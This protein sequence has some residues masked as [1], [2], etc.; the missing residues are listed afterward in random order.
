MLAP[1][2]AFERSLLDSFST[3]TGREEI[4]AGVEDLI[5]APD[6]SADW[7]GDN[8]HLREILDALLAGVRVS[9]TPARL[10]L[11]PAVIRNHLETLFSN[12]SIQHREFV[13]GSLAVLRYLTGRESV[14]AYWDGQMRSLPWDL[15]PSVR[16]VL[17][18]TER[19]LRSQI[20]SS[21]TE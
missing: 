20:E 1:R 15:S 9:G 13:A 7:L 18:S 12:H 8:G 6:F 3:E 5:E 16:R 17:E 14:Q 4:V 2:P 19:W 10:T 21:L 11:D